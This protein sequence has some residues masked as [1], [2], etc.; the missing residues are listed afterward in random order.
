MTTARRVKRAARQLFLLSQV[1]GSLDEARVR[2][3]VERII[4]SHRRGTLAILTQYQRLVRLAR[5]QRTAR[6]AS[7]TPLPEDLRAEVVTGVTRTYGPGIETSFVELP[8][9]IGG[10]RVQVGSDVYDGSVRARLEAIE[11]NL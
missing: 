10:M 4:Q 1:N 9:L 11:E 5:E 2:L 6:V 3:V 7:A 8:A